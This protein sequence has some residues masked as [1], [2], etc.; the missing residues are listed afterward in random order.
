[1]EKLPDTPEVKPEHL[2]TLHTLQDVADFLGGRS[3][4]LAP[5][6]TK[7]PFPI[8]PVYPSDS[9]LNQPKTKQL[10][11]IPA[12]T[13][14]VMRAALVSPPPPPTSSRPKAPPAP[15]QVLRQPIVPV[16]QDKLDRSI[17]QAV[18]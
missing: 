18:D 2:G 1:R 14:S 10:H 6:T 12:P 5:Q 11:E 15:T 4:S 16:A 3:S 13:E 7:L 8:A 9:A 17:L